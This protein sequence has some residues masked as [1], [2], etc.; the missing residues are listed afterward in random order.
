MRWALQA[1]GVSEQVQTAGDAC[2]SRAGTTTVRAVI[3][4]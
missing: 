1:G 4:C 3:P 2:I